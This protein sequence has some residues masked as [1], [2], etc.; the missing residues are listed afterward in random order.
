LMFSTI[1]G[2]IIAIVQ[3]LV[4]AILMKILWIKMRW[5]NGNRK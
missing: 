3:F 1:Y 2:L 5:R 4:K